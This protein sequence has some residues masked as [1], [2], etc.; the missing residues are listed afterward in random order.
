VARAPFSA[1]RPIGDFEYYERMAHFTES[2]TF[3]AVPGGL[4][5]PESD[6]TTYNGTM[7][8]LARRTYWSNVDDP[9]DTASVEWKSA[10]SFYQRRAY[11]DRFRW[12]WRDAPLQQSDFRRLIGQSNDLHRRALQDLGIV[13]A[14]HVLST[15][16]AY[17][18]VRLRRTSTGPDGSGWELVGSL[19]MWRLLPE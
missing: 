12:S 13:I 19:P 15:V 3:D 2:G 9:P 10:I 4:L 18:T 17:V 7:W 6:T 1:E 11:D 16:D 14:N 5:D 8:L